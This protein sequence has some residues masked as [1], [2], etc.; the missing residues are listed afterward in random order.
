LVDVSGAQH[1][2]DELISEVKAIIKRTVETW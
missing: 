2:K 1:G